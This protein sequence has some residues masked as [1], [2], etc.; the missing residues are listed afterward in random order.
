[1]SGPRGTIALRAISD[2]LPNYAPRLHH[3]SS[4]HTHLT[5]ISFSR[6]AVSIAL[7]Q[8]VSGNAKRGRGTNGR[9]PHCGIAKYIHSRNERAQHGKG[10]GFGVR[11]VF[12]FCLFRGS[13]FHRNSK[14][15]RTKGERGK[16][17]G[18]RGRESGNPLRYHAHGVGADGTSI[19][20]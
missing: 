16:E 4:P 13:L 18:E 2:P 9:F 19:M 7:E 5:Y 1:M 10:G 20:S 11:G 12:L 17:N 6:Q 3:Q 8:G 14:G 15:H